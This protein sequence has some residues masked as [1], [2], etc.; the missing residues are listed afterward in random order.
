[1]TTLV[2]ISHSE[3]IANGTKALLQQMAPDVNV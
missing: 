3:Q 2:I 1:M